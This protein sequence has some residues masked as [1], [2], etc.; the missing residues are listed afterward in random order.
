MLGGVDGGML[1]IMFNDGLVGL[2]G[3]SANLTVGQKVNI[4]HNDALADLHGIC[5]LQ[6]YSSLEIYLGGASTAQRNLNFC[7]F[8]V[9]FIS[10]S[11]LY[12]AI[13]AWCN[14]KAN[15]QAIYGPIGQWD[16]S[17]V[18]RLDK[19]NCGTFNDDINDWDTR[20]VTS[21]QVSSATDAVAPPSE[22]EREGSLSPLPTASR[23]PVPLYLHTPSRAMSS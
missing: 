7:S 9:A 5:G 23:Q 21:L 14:D 20:S 2:D 13:Q 18:D 8:K 11:E 4:Q 6:A 3:L 15:A 22:K 10:W 16:V 17:N 12:T 1:T 19:F